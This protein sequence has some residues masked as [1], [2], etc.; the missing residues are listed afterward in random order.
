MG[1]KAP[2][3]APQGRAASLTPPLRA[4]PPARR[5]P[6]A[7]TAAP[8]VAWALAAGCGGEAPGPRARLREPCALGRA[9]VLGPRHRGDGALLEHAQ[10]ER[11]G[12]RDRVARKA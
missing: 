9:R 4:P 12:Q 8:G 2:A 7:P 10:A 3:P 1:P 5:A 6:P 11:P